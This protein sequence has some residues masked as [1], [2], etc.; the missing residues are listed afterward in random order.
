MLEVPWDWRLTQIMIREYTVNLPSLFL[1]KGI[2][3]KVIAI[4]QW[5]KIILQSFGTNLFLHRKRYKGLSASHYQHRRRFDRRLVSSFM[6]GNPPWSKERT[7]NSNG[8]LIIKRKWP[9]VAAGSLW[10]D[11]MKDSQDERKVNRKLIPMLFRGN[12]LHF[13]MLDLRQEL[14]NQFLKEK[15]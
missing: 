15:L 14:T 5:I 10:K 1:S 8:H 7:C 3:W 11:V 2:Y 4:S 9:T 12:S 13:F 6:K